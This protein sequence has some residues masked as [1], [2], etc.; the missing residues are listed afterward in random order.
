M[1]NT[2]LRIR[3]GDRVIGS[4]RQFNEKTIDRRAAT[5]EPTQFSSLAVL[6]FTD[7][8]IQG[9]S[10]PTVEQLNSQNLLTGGNEYGA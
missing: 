6:W 5:L 1:L 9:F 7:A 4:H 10:S 8:R 3:Y 2:P